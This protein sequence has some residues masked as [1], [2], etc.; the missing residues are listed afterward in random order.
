MEQ[1]SGLIVRCGYGA[2]TVQA[3]RVHR[4]V[5]IDTTCELPRPLGIVSVAHDPILC[6][7]SLNSLKPRRDDISEDVIATDVYCCDGTGAIACK[8]A[9]R[10]DSICPVAFRIVAFRQFAQTVT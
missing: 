6:S 8:I 7:I 10:R 2:K 4:P 3:N 9:I 5:Q 1:Q